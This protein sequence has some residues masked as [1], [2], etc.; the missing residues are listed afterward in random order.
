MALP[1]PA[2]GSAAPEFSLDTTSGSKVTLSALRG[3]RNVLLAFFPAAFISTCTAELCAF[4][5]AYSAFEGRDV[6]VI[7]ISVDNVPSLKEF[8]AKYKMGVDLASD[9]RREVSRAYGTLMEPAFVSN[10]AYFLIDKQGILRW[11]HVEAQP[12]T[13]RDNAEILAESEKL[14]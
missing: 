11:A 9:L 10:R 12:G 2:V 5:D 8:K 14:G 4:S 1:V 13:R 6:E 3:N 7:P